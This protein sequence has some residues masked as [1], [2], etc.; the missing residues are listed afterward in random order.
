M[1]KRTRLNA[2]TYSYRQFRTEEKKLY[3]RLALLLGIIVITVLALWFWGTTFI[4]IIGALGNTGNSEISTGLNIPLIKPVVHSLPEFT[5]KGKITFSGFTSSDAQV[6]LLINGVEVSKTTADETGNFT[7]VDVT[8]REGLNF[9]K[10]FSEYN[11]EKSNEET[12]LITLDRQPP[13]L[14]IT[15]PND[16]EILSKTTTITVKGSTEPGAKV[17]INSIQSTLD[18]SGGFTYILSVKTG[19]NKIN[20]KATDKAGNTKEVRLVVTIQD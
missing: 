7:F 4:Q 8:L 19:D 2:P 14:Q 18:Q 16:G 12:A 9:V 6:V 10:F 13:T 1:N 15:S 20:I 17:F 3:R 5:N 11:G